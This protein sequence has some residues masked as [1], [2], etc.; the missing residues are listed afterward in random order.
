[1]AARRKCIESVSADSRHYPQV[2]GARFAEGGGRFTGMPRMT[3]RLRY[4]TL[5]LRALCRLLRRLRAG[6]GP[7]R[8]EWHGNPPRKN[9]H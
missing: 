5:K 3:I 9:A 8:I 6:R 7:E 1:M 4:L 2:R